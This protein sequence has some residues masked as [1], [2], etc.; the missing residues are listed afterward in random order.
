[1]RGIDT[2]WYIQKSVD[3]YKFE[4]IRYGVGDRGCV[5]SRAFNKYI[6]SWLGESCI[7]M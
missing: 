2:T 7:G 4:S 3:I 5:P 6:V 1:M